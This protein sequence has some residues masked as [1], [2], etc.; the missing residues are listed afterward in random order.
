MAQIGKKG[1]KMDVFNFF[2]KLS[3]RFCLETDKLS[4][5]QIA[6]FFKLLYLLNRLTVLPLPAGG[7]SPSTGWR[8]FSLYRL[9]AFLRLPA[10]GVSPST[11]WQRFS[12]YRLA[13]FL[14][15]PAGGVSPAT[16]RRRFSRYRPAAFLPLPAGGVS[17]STGLAAFLPLPAWR[18]FSL[19]RPGGVSPSTGLAAFLPLPASGVSPSTGWPRWWKSV[20]STHQCK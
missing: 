10:G 6:R 17:P 8:R 19:Y 1:P 2:S 18:R 5:N 20:L 15:L 7:V 11:G 13:V 16:G 3:L 12:L 14:P 4:T 9:A